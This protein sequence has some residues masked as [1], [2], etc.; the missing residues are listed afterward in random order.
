MSRPRETLIP[1]TVCATM[2][3]FVQRISS[4][5]R[6]LLSPKNFPLI[7]V[8]LRYPIGRSVSSRL[9]AIASLAHCSNG[10]PRD[11]RHRRSPG[12]AGRPVRRRTWQFR[13]DGTGA[14]RER[15][16]RSR[17]RARGTHAY[18][19]LLAGNVRR[20]VPSTSRRSIARARPRWYQV[21]EG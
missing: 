2:S 11:E 20:R 14:V 6:H 12:S 5:H 15:R 9:L 18:R 10:V 21:V 8:S 16:E 1:P 13:H 19:E 7:T 17:R 3:T 4:K